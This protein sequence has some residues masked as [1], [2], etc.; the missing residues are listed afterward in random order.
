MTHHLGRAAWLTCRR[1]VWLTCALALA[2]CGGSDG[3]PGATLTG[4]AATPLTIP[5]AVGGTQAL[6]VTGTYGNG[7]T[8]TLASG[9]SSRTACAVFSIVSMVLWT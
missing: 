3:G 6:T 9:T 1:A 8:A 4:I 7:T 5:L 2:A